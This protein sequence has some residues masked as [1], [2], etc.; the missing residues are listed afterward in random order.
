MPVIIGARITAERPFTPS[1]GDLHYLPSALFETD[2]AQVPHDGQDKPFSIWPLRPA[3][4]PAG[5]NWLLRCAWLRPDPPAPAVLSLDKLRIGHRY[6]T[7][8]E[9]MY[10]TATH[11][12]LA[13][14]PVLSQAEVTFASPAY[15][16]HNGSSLL[17]PDPRRMADSWR[18]SWNAWLPDPSD[19]TTGE[20][21]WP[22]ISM[23]IEL[24]A[25]D[26]RTTTTDSGHGRDQAGFTGTATL[27]LARKATVPAR[28]AFS[29]LVRF[30]EFSG[31]GAQTTH[32]FGATRSI[33]D[34]W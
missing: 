28:S 14:G 15:F 25:Y 31:T 34:Q 1:T 11:A 26:L 6:C 8:T 20:N 3:P 2:G 17:T 4:G 12:Q 10:R 7:V 24:A 13:A 33:P 9:T 16:A 23:T 18:R 5:L 27:R 19:L 21:I 32:G 22:E 30:A 29:T